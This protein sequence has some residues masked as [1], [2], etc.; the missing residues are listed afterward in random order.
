MNKSHVLFQVHLYKD[1]DQNFKYKSFNIILFAIFSEKE[2]KRKHK[3]P[4]LFRTEKRP[5]TPATPSSRECSLKIDHKLN[6]YCE[7]I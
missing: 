5:S 3:T 4:K 7:S 2:K 6:C 1:Q